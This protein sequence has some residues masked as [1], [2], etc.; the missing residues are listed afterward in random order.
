[1]GGSGGDE[2]A[3][4]WFARVTVRYLAYLWVLVLVMAWALGDMP[5]G[6]LTLAVLPW[7]L[8]VFVTAPAVLLFALVS[9]W[10]RAAW[11]RPAVAAG[12]AVPVLVLAF[13][14]RPG[15]VVAQVL[16]GLLLLP[17]R[18]RARLPHREMTT[19]PAR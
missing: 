3:G 12:L 1:M 4:R 2:H 15:L 7:Y 17:G 13:P 5:D 16:F 6:A 19:G 9:P 18:A 11:V 8:A 10:R 14:G